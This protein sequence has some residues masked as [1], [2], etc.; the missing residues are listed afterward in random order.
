MGTL[1]LK[2]GTNTVARRRTG[3]PALR[4]CARCLPPGSRNRRRYTAGNMAAPLSIH[5]L[6]QTA[7][8]V[9]WEDGHQS[10]YPGNYLRSRCRCAECI[11]ETTGRKVLDDSTIAPDLRYQ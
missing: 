1:L 9:T 4:R 6:G 11:E 5:G 3:I 2:R 10:I 7:I 8:T